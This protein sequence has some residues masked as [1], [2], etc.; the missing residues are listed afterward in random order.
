LLGIIDGTVKA[1]PETIT[2]T[3][4][5]GVVQEVNPEFLIWYN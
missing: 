4:V 5:D 2:K 3:I 1:P